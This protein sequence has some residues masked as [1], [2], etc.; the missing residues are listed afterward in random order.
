MGE[1]GSFN[2]NFRLGEIYPEALGVHAAWYPAASVLPSL[3][4][5]EPTQERYPD[6]HWVDCGL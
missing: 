3:V 5:E 6:R 4:V 1:L 2:E